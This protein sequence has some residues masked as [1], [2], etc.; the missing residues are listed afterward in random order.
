MKLFR[1]VRKL[2]DTQPDAG[3]AK[4]EHAMDLA[5][6]VTDRIRERAKSVSPFREVLGEMLLRASHPNT[7]LIADAFEAGQESRIFK[8]PPNG[9]G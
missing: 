9:R 3:D 1:I 2:L 8:G 4:Y 5:T 7:L 6:E